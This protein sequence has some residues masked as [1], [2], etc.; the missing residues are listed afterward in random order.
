MN[1]KNTFLIGAGLGLALGYLLN[2]DSG[3]EMRKQTGEMVKDQVDQALIKSNE[4]VDTAANAASKIK[5]Q[6]NE[7]LKKMNQAPVDDREIAVFIEEKIQTLKNEL[8]N[9]V[10]KP[11]LSTNHVNS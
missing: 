1:N 6:G 2:S 10:K 3:R 9:E 8:L 7:Y 4:W 11:E 5:E